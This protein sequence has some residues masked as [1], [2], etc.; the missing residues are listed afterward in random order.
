M[1]LYYV[2]VQFVN[3]VSC[4]CRN[5]RK[6]S[7]WK[8][9]YRCVDRMEKIQSILNTLIPAIIKRNEIRFVA[10]IGKP[11]HEFLDVDRAYVSKETNFH[12]ELSVH[13]A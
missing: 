3:D 1:A 9:P 5:K 7:F 6:I 4:C 11:L 2:R 8:E 10:F 13:V 12:F